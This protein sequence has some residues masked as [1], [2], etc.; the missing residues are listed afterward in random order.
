MK[1]YTYFNP[2]STEKVVLVIRRRIHLKVSG[3]VQGVFYRVSTR[4]KARELGIYGDVKNVSDGSVEINAEGD[5]TKLNELIS[6][7][8][9]GPSHARVEKVEVKW[10]DSIEGYTDFRIERSG[11]N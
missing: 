9:R 7:V 11:W 10:L 1:E 6:W 8:H 2:M 4:D 5:E 3:R